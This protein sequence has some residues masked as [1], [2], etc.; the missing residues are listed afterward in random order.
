MRLLRR[1]LQLRE[2]RSA[3]LLRQLIKTEDLRDKKRAARALM[4]AA[5]LVRRAGLQHLVTEATE[6][7]VLALAQAGEVLQGEQLAA[8]AVA[9]HDPALAV[10]P[11]DGGAT[12]RRQVIRDALAE[13]RSC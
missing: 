9:V 4:N 10:Q 2:Q 1:L 8:I 3:S 11:L 6:A 5:L 13:A 7:E 12:V